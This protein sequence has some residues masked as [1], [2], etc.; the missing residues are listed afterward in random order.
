[1][2]CKT[3]AH[4]RPL[5]EIMLLC[6]HQETALHHHRKGE[7]LRIG[8]SFI[9]ALCDP[10]IN[11]TKDCSKKEELAIVIHYV[12]VEA[13]KILFENLRT[14]SKVTTLDS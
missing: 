10:V 2:T 8:K 4:I 14:F 5:S 3:Y 9:L 6:S 11:E 12:D 13:E 7:E 1:M